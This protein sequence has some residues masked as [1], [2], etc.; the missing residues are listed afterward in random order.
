MLDAFGGIF[1]KKPIA[2]QEGDAPDAKT[3]ETKNEEDKK[4][5]ISAKI[6]TI[7]AEESAVIEKG[8]SKKKKSFWLKIAM[9]LLLCILLAL[10]LLYQ[11]GFI[12]FKKSVKSSW[13]QP[14]VTETIPPAP[15]A[16]EIVQT[17]EAKTPADTSVSTEK[18][19][20]ASI[21][22]MRNMEAEKTFSIQIKAIPAS[23]EARR[24]VEALKAKGE[25]AFSLRIAINGREAWDRIFIGRFSTKE[26]ASQY[27]EQNKFKTKY[28]GSIVRNTSTMD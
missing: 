9:V 23:D 25:D 15:R 2:I 13:Q 1:R 17:A 28:P 8:E 16:A 7:K 27:L 22:P 14:V 6:D 4:P 26:E 21:I 5:A 19:S 3:A 11:F 20:S 12:K 24:D 18:E 10:G